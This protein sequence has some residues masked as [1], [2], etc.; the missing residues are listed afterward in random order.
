MLAEND[1]NYIE[2]FLASD[3]KLVKYQVRG[4]T[5]DPVM[6]HNLIHQAISSM[7]FKL[8]AFIDKSTA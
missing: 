6:I 1:L 3:I 5:H 8:G 4:M 2:L 7:L